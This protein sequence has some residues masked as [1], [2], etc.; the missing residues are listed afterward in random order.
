MGGNPKFIGWFRFRSG[1]H[2]YV[3]LGALF[4]PRGFRTHNE[5]DGCHQRDW[6]EELL[7]PTRVHRDLCPGGKPWR[8]RRPTPLPVREH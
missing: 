6:P 3:A 1:I 2:R 8:V 5:G 4:R 7:T